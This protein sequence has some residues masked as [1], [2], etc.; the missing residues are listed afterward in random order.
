MRYL[1]PFLLSLLVISI[2]HAQDKQEPIRVCVSMLKNS[3]REYVN[4]TWQ[5]N[6][7]IKAF[8][9]INKSKDVKKGKAAAIQAIPLEST[10]EPDTDVRDKECGFVLHTNLIEVLQ[11]GDHKIGVP[12]P[13][14]IDVGTTA[15]DPRARTADYLTATVE[16]RLMRAGNPET[17][18][19][20]LVSE[21]GQ[22]PEETLVSQIMDGSGCQSGS[23][24][25]SK[26]PSLSAAVRRDANLFN[27]F[28]GRTHG[29]GL[30]GLG[31]NA[32]QRN[33]AHSAT[34][35][36][37]HVAASPQIGLYPFG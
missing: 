25:I 28:S 26:I 2:V 13:G 19:S 32:D 5:R 4:P 16:Y 35:D 31:G 34:A 6:E 21:E 9:R 33:A 24:R 17:W 27:F 11:A 12:P 29:G 20:S 10:D 18:A 30:L 14:A 8:E 3:S 1:Y 37:K 23:G 22:L 15:G 36:G 7:L